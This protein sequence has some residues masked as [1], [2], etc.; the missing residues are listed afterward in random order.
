[1]TQRERERDKEFTRILLPNEI[2]PPPIHSWLP[3]TSPDT[4][5]FLILCHVE[6][7]PN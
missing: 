4:A 2:L 1:M 5:N 3:C 6:F 7:F